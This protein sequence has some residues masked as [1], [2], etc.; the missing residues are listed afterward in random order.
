MNLRRVFW[1][2]RYRCRICTHCIVNISILL[3]MLVAKCCNVIELRGL[4][5]WAGLL[6][7]LIGVCICMGL[8]F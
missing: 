2:G 8:N 6:M 5:I 3:Y 7:F 1:V 4:V